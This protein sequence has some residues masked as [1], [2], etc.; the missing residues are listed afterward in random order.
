M[1]LTSSL[2]SQFA[3][4]NESVI[5]S[6]IH[7]GTGVIVDAPPFFSDAFTDSDAVPLTRTSSNAIFTLLNVSPVTVQLQ[8]LDAR[9]T[10]V[11]CVSV[12]D[13]S[14]MDVLPLV[15]ACELLI[16]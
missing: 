12:S 14:V 2:N 5:Y 16:P 10:N 9:A 15:I 6:C 11:S 3:C 8:I 13:A 7:N 1:I 4:A